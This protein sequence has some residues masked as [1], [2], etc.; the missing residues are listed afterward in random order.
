VS[1]FSSVQAGSQRIAS[2]SVQGVDIVKLRSQSALR[3]AE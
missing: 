1:L 2:L 3:A